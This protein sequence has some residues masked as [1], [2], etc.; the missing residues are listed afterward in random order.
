MNTQQMLELGQECGLQYV[1]EAYS[2]VMNHWDMFFTYANVDAELDEFRK[3]LIECGLLKPKGT[4]HEDM[5]Y[6]FGDTTIKE[7]LGSLSET[8]YVKSG[9][10]Y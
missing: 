9:R 6:T 1:S 3:E 10:G 7:A 2:N 5:Y 8:P 4:V